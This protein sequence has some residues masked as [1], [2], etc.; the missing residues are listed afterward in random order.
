MLAGFSFQ[1]KLYKSML[2]QAN[3]F[4][5]EFIDVE[6]KWMKAARD[7]MVNHPATAF[8]KDVVEKHFDNLMKSVSKPK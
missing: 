8:T 7:S 1:Q 5:K 2:D 4:Q 3:D 6:H